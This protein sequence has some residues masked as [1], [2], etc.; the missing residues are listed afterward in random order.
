MNITLHRARRSAAERLPE[1]SQQATLRSLGDASVR[2]I[3]ERY[4]DA[5]E[6]GEVEELAA[7]L[8]EDATFAMPPYAR[9]WRGC[10]VIAVFA[11]Q[12]VHRYLAPDVFPRFGLPGALSPR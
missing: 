7:L 1:R 4:M 5:W 8:A 6:R 11:A 10:D 9:W 2:Q 3:V 12:P